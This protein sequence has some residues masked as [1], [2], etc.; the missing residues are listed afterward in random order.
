MLTFGAMDKRP[1][2]AACVSSGVNS[3]QIDDLFGLEEEAEKVTATTGNFDVDSLVDNLVNSDDLSSASPVADAA[4]AA[5]GAAAAKRGGDDGLFGSLLLQN[6]VKSRSNGVDTLKVDV[7]S[8]NPDDEALAIENLQLSKPTIDALASRGIERLFPIQGAVYAPMKAGRDVIGRART[9]TGKTLAFLL[10]VVELLQA[11][12]ASGTSI[13]RGRSPKC[14]VIAPTR[15]LAQQVERE[16]ASMCGKNDFNTVVVYGG[17]SIE[18]QSRAL[19]KGADIVV[20]TPGRLID[21]VERGNL[22]LH[23][24]RFCILDEADQMLQ[25][26][27]EEDVER[28][29]GEMPDMNERQTFLF[30]ATVPKWVLGL[31]KRYLRDP[32]LVDL[33]GDDSVS[34]ADT[35]ETLACMV[36]WQAKADAVADCI[37]VYG[38]GKRTI[39]FTKTKKDADDLSGHL[40]KVVPNAALHGD[41][42]QHQREKTLKQFRDGVIK[43]LIATDVAARGLDIPNVELVIQYELPQDVETFVHRSGRTGRAGKSGTALSLYTEREN[44]MLR[45]IARETGA[46][47]KHVSPPTTADVLEAAASQISSRLDAVHPELVQHF[48]PAATELLERDDGKSAVEA[49]A[50]AFATMSGYTQP[51]ERKSLINGSKGTATLLLSF[52]EGCTDRRGNPMR[53]PR[54]VRDA[55][56]ILGS[57]LDGG[58]S[59]EIG[60]VIVL[61]GHEG[62][63]VLFDI[64]DAYH[65]AIVNGSYLDAFTG[66]KFSAPKR[67]PEEAKSFLAANLTRDEGGYGGR[68]GGGGRRGGGGR[69]G[70]RGGYGGGGG[71]R[72]DRGGGGYGDRGGGYGRMS[73][74]GGGYGGG[75]GGGYGGGRGGGYG[76]GRRDDRFGG[77]Y[78]GRDRG[79]DRD[80]YSGFRDGGDRGGGGRRK[81][82]SGS[83][84]GGGGSKDPLSLDDFLNGTD[85]FG[86]SW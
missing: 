33:V 47:F 53:I 13:R 45:N 31:S 38:N 60:K 51:P 46:K 10:P 61:R 37:T 19:S 59:G 79:Y 18:T 12:R 1:S 34:V 23:D 54:E 8:L 76:G 28:I 16:A 83:K 26:G 42:S 64:P 75:R 55:M 36:P 81:F 71:R 21:L 80:G 41:V 29:L 5:A 48:T 78:G 65:D 50:S 72:Y 66:L 27:F 20:G 85:G 17:V 84:K 56:G 7:A 30:S 35:V 22:N 69:Y 67:L 86:D 9:G 15:E 82:S 70:D 57:V 32:L 62:P 44:R 14:L 40:G 25:Q 49:L 68:G 63:A 39:I 43:C 2:I 3:P 77:G 52:E 58:E 4:S 11:A 74:R 6:A 73:D 24:I